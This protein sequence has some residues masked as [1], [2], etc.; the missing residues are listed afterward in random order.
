MVSWKR[1]L[2]VKFYSGCR[3]ICVF[4]LNPVDAS[5]SPQEHL[6]V[7]NEDPVDLQF[8]QSGYLFLASEDTAHI[9]EENYRTQRS[10]PLALSYTG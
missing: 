2:A 10:G 5:V 7:L 9:M 1:L 8:N 4:I 6:D 3:N